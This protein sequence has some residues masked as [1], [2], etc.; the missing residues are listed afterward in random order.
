MKEEHNTRLD[1]IHKELYPL[2]ESFASKDPCF[3]NHNPD[4]FLHILKQIS[5]IKKCLNRT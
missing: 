2:I 3:W 1:I 5:R 4:K